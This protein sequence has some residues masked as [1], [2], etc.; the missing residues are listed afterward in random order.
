MRPPVNDLLYVLDQH[1]PRGRQ[2]QTKAA[3]R[4]DAAARGDSQ[5]AT[6][7]PAGADP[8]ASRGEARARKRWP[9]IGR[10]QVAFRNSAR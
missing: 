7:T 10:P 8:H 4:L 9:I 5:A 1:G 2:F 6:T 3:R